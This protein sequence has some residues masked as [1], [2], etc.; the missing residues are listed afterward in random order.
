MA[1]MTVS[2]YLSEQGSRTYVLKS[3]KQEAQTKYGWDLAVQPYHHALQLYEA[4]FGEITPVADARYDSDEDG[5][6]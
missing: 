6:A 4:K 1:K 3:K 2:H 5:A